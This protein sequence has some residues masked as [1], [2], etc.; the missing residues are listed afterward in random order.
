MST[1]PVLV[2]GASGNVGREVVRALVAR[3]I[4]VRVTGRAGKAP[5]D[6]PPGVESVPLDFARPETF[7]P[8]VRG[9]RGLFLL[10]PPAIADVD[11]TLN[12]LVDRAIE[13]GVEHI[14]F[15][16][17]M[18][19]DRQR[20]IPHHRVERHLLSKQ[21]PWTMLRC[22]FFAQNLQDAYRQEIS[23]KNEIYLPAGRGKVAFVDVRDVAELAA[24]AF[25]DVAMRNQAWDLT[26]PEAITFDEVV[27]LLSDALGRP[28]RYAA[29][30]VP[31]FVWRQRRLGLPWGMVAVRTVLH[32]GLRFGNA[33]RVDP[34]LGNLLGRRPF[35]MAEYIRD[36]VHLW[37]A[38][39]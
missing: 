17:V 9:I 31:G 4:P 37:P 18:G 26:G 25:G 1:S 34:A 15:L 23:E 3:G 16:S 38:A 29:A 20:W 27:R 11:S 36:H 6:A 39:F 22:G 28:I 2:T 30:S 8:A 33:E 19:A 10:R 12:P 35:S 24:M 7:E 32:V 14:V 21:V 5:P 13:A